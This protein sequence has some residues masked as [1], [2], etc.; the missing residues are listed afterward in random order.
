MF[1]SIVLSTVICLFFSFQSEAQ[2]NKN[3]K[4]SF[5]LGVQTRVNPIYLLKNPSMGYIPNSNLIAQ[6][7]RHYTG[8][9]IIF[10][11]QRKLNENVEFSLNP[12]IRW[13]YLYDEELFGGQAVPRYPFN[14]KKTFILDTYMDFKYLIQ[15]EKT[16]KS[17]GIGF[18][19]C[20]LGTKFTMDR[21]VVI[22][23][24]AHINTTN[25]SFLFPAIYAT[26]GL[27]IMEKL[28]CEVKF[29]YCW[30]N[31]D[32]IIRNQFF[33]PELRVSYDLFDF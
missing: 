32:I 27:K 5:S 26:A 1:N 15:G 4:N 17:I 6:G 25:E 20:G 18:A 30:S 23:N 31:P 7:D 29:G 28:Y 13:D 14:T 9:G 3:S 12:C 8:P 10:A 22:N 21:V 2:E 16:R 19:A 24:I 11:W 33:F